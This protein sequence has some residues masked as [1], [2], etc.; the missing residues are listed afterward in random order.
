MSAATSRGVLLWSR[1]TLRSSG[2]QK[3]N[4]E[5]FAVTIQID[6]GSGTVSLLA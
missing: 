1:M 3:F 4:Y 2:L 6:A 5:A